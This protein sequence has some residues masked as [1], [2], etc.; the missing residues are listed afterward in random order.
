MNFVDNLKLS[1][2]VFFGLIL[3]ISP[4]LSQAADAPESQPVMEIPS[5]RHDAGTHWEGAVVKH[6]FEVRNTGDSELRILNV[7]P[8]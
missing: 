2:M 8:G 5:P 6:S 1:I 4:I 3:A 7:K